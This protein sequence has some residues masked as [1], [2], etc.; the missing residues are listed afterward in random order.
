MDLL[1]KFV[2]KKKKKNMV[3]TLEYGYGRT[4][5]PTQRT[6]RKRAGKKKKNPGINPGQPAGKPQQKKREKKKPLVLTLGSPPEKGEKKK[7]PGINT[8][9]SPLE[10]IGKKKEKKK[11]PWAARRKRAKKK[12]PGPDL[13]FKTWTDEKKKNPDINPGRPP[14]KGENKK[15]LV[16]IWVSGPRLSG[17]GQMRKKKFKN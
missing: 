6:R 15:T 17:P 7:N 16:P 4:Y 1:E 11:K 14:E 9:G 5:M 10:N 8:L 3:L 2:P 12:N 13:G